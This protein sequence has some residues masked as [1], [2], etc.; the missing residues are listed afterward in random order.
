MTLIVASHYIFSAACYFLNL[1]QFFPAD[2]QTFSE[3]RL[4]PN[5]MTFGGSFLRWHVDVDNGLGSKSGDIDDGFALAYLMRS[6]APIASIGTVFGNVSEAESF[7][8]S[9]ALLTGLGAKALLINGAHSRKSFSEVGFYLQTLKDPI[10]CLM[11]G[12]LTNLAACLERGGGQA[13]QKIVFVAGDSG[14]AGFLPPIWPL[15][16]NI[17]QDRRAARKV[18]ASSL[19]LTCMPL[20]QARRLSVG[21]RELL[22]IPGTWGQ[23]FRSLSERWLLRKRRLTGTRRFAIWDLAAAAYVTHPEWFE[24][25]TTTCRLSRMGRL[26]FGE[27]DRKVDLIVDFDPKLVWQDF[28]AC[29]YPAP[30]ARNSKS[31]DTPQTFPG[32]TKSI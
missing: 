20:N 4:F 26:W 25:K 11:L 32:L 13:I 1:L 23:M 9:R 2:R 16:F 19:S 5:L 12:P 7:E 18:L 24:V 31:E 21:D 3:G 14:S 28:L 6:K 22:Q 10:S 17:T 8:N 30:T 27:G 29:F 15:E